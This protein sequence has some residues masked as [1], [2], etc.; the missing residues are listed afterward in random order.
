MNT[1]NQQVKKANRLFLLELLFV[2]LV[3]MFGGWFFSRLST[4]GSL[5]ASQLIFAFLPL[6]FVLFNGKDIG[7][8]IPLGPFRLSTLLMALL[9]TVLLLPVIAAVNAF[10]MIFVDNYVMEMQSGLEGESLLCSLFAVALVPAFL[11]ELVYRGIF[12]G[13]YRKL[14]IVK[15]AVFCG[16]VFGVMHMNFNQFAYAL[17]LGTAF[18]FLMEAT[19]SILYCMAAHFFINGWST[20]ISSLSEGT[21]AVSGAALTQADMVNAFCVYAV[22]GAVT[23]TLAVC[24]LIWIAKHSGRLD[25]VREHLK[26]E[27]GGITPAFCI[28]AFLGIGFMVLQEF[29]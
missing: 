7:F 11:E 5:L 13:S 25:Y 4:V 19:G 14:G 1:E 18:C 27:K 23:G 26:G 28:A 15:G 21:E 22:I 24:V 12:F 8:E 17:L 20:V 16:L 3:S 10:S 2:I 29:I 9:F 6:L